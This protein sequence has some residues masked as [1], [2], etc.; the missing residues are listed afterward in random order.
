MYS[1]QTWSRLS[2]LLLLIQ[3]E[4]PGHIWFSFSL[5]SCLRA[6]FLYPASYTG[7]YCPDK[8]TEVASIYFGPVPKWKIL[9]LSIL[10][11]WPSTSSVFSSQL[12][13]LYSHHIFKII[14]KLMEDYYLS[15]FF[16]VICI[17]ES[18][19]EMAAVW[20]TVHLSK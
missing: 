9:R 1:W 20:F 6:V 11:L 15:I 17:T 7:F 10:F 18:N 8:V 3:S 16:L 4:S 12:T 2:E 19:P 13:T 14:L 5:Y